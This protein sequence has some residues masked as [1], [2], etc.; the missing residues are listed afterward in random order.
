M[1]SKDDFISGIRSVIVADP[2]STTLKNFICF[3][4]YA[5]FRMAVHKQHENTIAS[6]C[7]TLGRKAKNYLDDKQNNGHNSN[8]CKMLF[9][10]VENQIGAALQ[11]KNIVLKKSLSKVSRNS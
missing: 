9:H 11:L 10:I 1:M 3:N 2:G 5:E 6:I 4:K 8:N 7:N